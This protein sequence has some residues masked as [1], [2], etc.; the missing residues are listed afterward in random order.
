MEYQNVLIQE[1][2][3]I[4]PHCDPKVERLEVAVVGGWRCIV[5]KAHYTVGDKVLFIPPD[6]ILPE[7]YATAIGVTQYLD[8]GNRVKTVK[9]R[10]EVSMGIVAQ[11]P[12]SYTGKPVGTDLG[13]MLEITK[14]KPTANAPSGKSLKPGKPGKYT[15]C[16][17]THPLAWRYPDT[18]NLRH[19]PNNI[20][21]GEIVVVT[22]KVHGSSVRVGKV[23]AEMSE[24]ETY[25][26]GSREHLRRYPTE[27]VQMCFTQEPVAY[28]AAWIKNFFAKGRFYRPRKDVPSSQAAAANW[29]W[30]VGSR[31][32]VQAMVEWL[33]D[34]VSVEKQVIVNGEVY[35]S[36]VQKM[37]YGSPQALQYA[38]FDILI[39]G[40]FVPWDKVVQ[41]C[42]QFGV[43]TVP[44]L[45]RGP[46]NFEIVAKLAD[47]KTVIG[48]D[49]HIREG[50][51]VKTQ[52]PTA[53][54]SYKYVSD[55]YLLWKDGKEE[56]DTHSE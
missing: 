19:Y 33:Y 38:I 7:A 49:A 54:Q 52:S 2:R 37:Q 9:L 24:P 39:D 22:E 50:V 35:G 3:Q 6:S 30:F 29:W 51:V 31:P 8:K 5:P 26:V 32:E 23:R 43:I 27:S 40:H 1:V 20:P 42:Q 4:V 16:A 48:N 15:E 41:Y 28:A 47:G 53:R 11:I 36:N 17:R 55:S 25:F 12:A 10:Q 34:N 18:A 21:D 44:E 56:L 45:W 46:Y 14:W 13:E